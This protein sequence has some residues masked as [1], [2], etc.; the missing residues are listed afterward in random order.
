MNQLKLM[1]QGVLSADL[2]A[3]GWWDF[4]TDAEAL[5]LPGGP[6]V[7]KHPEESW[8]MAADRVPPCS[9]APAPQN[10]T[11]SPSCGTELGA[12]EGDQRQPLGQSSQEKVS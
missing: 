8:L 1:G 12:H 9:G 11:P 2:L 4:I 7:H 10:R 6:T 3:S 5:S